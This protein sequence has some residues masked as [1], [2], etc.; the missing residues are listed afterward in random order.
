MSLSAEHREIWIEEKLLDACEQFSQFIYFDYYSL[1]LFKKKP[2][3]TTL[4]KL[5][6]GVFRCL[7]SLGD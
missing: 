1:P 4:N 2:Q 3:Q 7:L 6:D 5:C